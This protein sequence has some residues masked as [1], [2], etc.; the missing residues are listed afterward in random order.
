[1]PAD[2]CVFECHVIVL[3]VSRE[4]ANERVLSPPTLFASRQTTAPTLC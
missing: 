3:T 1:M 4:A 2:D